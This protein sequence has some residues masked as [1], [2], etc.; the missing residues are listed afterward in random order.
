[1][2][3]GCHGEQDNIAHYLRCPLLWEII[4][5]AYPPS[6]NVGTEQAS[7]QYHRTA[8]GPLR[9]RHQPP[10]PHGLQAGGLVPIICRLGMIPPNQGAI[11]GLALAF[12][13]YH[14]IKNQKSHLFHQASVTNDFSHIILAASNFSI[15]YAND[16]GFLRA[17]RPG[18]RSPEASLLMTEGG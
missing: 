1:M 6:I 11:H 2:P 14:G 5:R 3:F 15:M 7:N 16:L 9:Y 4:E 12:S 17:V 8:P 13:I 18:L 10:L